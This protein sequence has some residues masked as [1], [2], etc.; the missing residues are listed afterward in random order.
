MA[1]YRTTQ[2]LA[3]VPSTGVGDQRRPP[4]ASFLTSFCTSGGM[5]WAGGTGP[6]NYVGGRS[7]GFVEKRTL[8]KAP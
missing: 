6:G 8:R 1:A 3:A 7:E 4:P 5:P 2:P